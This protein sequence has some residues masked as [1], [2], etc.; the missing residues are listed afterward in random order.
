MNIDARAR[1]IAMAMGVVPRQ[2]FD[3]RLKIVG[4]TIVDNAEV[5]NSGFGKS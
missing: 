1:R 4:P 2:G 5:A 3:R